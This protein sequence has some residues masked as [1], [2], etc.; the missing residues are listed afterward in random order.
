VRY[1]NWRYDSG[2][3]AIHRAGAPVVCVGNLT[4]GGT[5]K[6]PM[7]AHLAQWF[8]QRGV[9]VA[10]V[11][12][13]YKSASGG[14]N[15]EA[16]ELAQ[17]LPGVPHVQNAD[18]VAGAEEAIKKHSA[19][20]I[21]L[22]DGF[23]HRRL[24]R[25]LDL[26]MVDS[27]EPYGFDHIFPRGTLR[28]PL[29]GLRRAGLVALSRANLIDAA[30]R[31][32]IRARLQLLAPQA[33]WIEVAHQ[34]QAL[35]SASGKRAELDTMAGKKIAAFCG[36]GNPAGFRAT[37]DALGYEG[38]AFREFPDHHAYTPGDI[39]SLANWADEHNADALVCTHKDLVKISA[40]GF[41]SLP[42]W[43]VEIGIQI[44]T[45]GDALAAQLEPLCE[46]L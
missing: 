3:A 30:Q 43:A 27:L 46:T 25:D 32:A 21:L 44:L 11:S 38:C 39:A 45:G 17:R 2:R 36:I 28:E 31:K 19:Q 12:R 20:L 34:P 5:G 33:G 4:L 26:V 8:G 15:D 6:T 13:G 41:G 1:R 16:R 22:D 35:I 14:A 42:L 37:L 29:A 9:R 7:I 23:Q 18:R 10:I 40:V 24:H